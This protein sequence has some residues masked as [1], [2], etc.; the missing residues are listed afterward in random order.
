MN[1]KVVV[2]FPGHCFADLF[3]Y[4]I[5]NNPSI[6]LVRSNLF[7]S[8]HLLR[9]LSV[10]RLWLRD[11][12]K[13]RL[14]LRDWHCSDLCWLGPGG[15]ISDCE[16]VEHVECWRCCVLEMLL[17]SS[18]SLLL[19]LLL[20]DPLAMMFSWEVWPCWRWLQTTK[21]PGRSPDKVSSG[22]ATHSASLLT[23]WS[24]GDTPVAMDCL[25]G[26][27]CLLVFAGKCW[28]GSIHG[29]NC[30]HN[31]VSQFHHWKN[32]LKW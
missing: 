5:T 8:P 29:L 25:L 22:V 4:G 27:K 20:C 6:V 16:R 15:H 11:L 23:G 24:G 2:S 18:S 17:S 28:K 3:L 7:W 26:F 30:W 21:H 9:T 14:F 31:S 19:P 13:I 32:D 10:A 1:F 12:S